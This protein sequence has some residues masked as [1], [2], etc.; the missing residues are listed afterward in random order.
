[1]AWSRSFVL[2]LI[3]ILVSIASVHAEPII[4]NHTCTD[5]SKIP[6]Y[7]IEKAK[8]ITFHY[9]HTSHGSQ[10]VSGLYAW[11]EEYPALLSVAV[12][13]SSKQGLP[14]RETPRAL[15]IY[16]GNP[17]ETYIEPEDYWDSAD[18]RS[19][20]KAV[21]GT[22]KYQ[23][24]MWSWC[25]QQSYN[26]AD[27]T[28]RYLYTLNRFEKRFP[29]MRFIYMTGH[30]DGSGKEGNL[31]KRNQQVRAYCRKHDKILFDFAD[32]E[33]YDPSGKYFLNKG[34]KDTC[35][36][37][38]GNWA[39][40]WIGAHPASLLAEISS[41]CDS[42]EHSERLNCALKGSAFW[43]M[44]ARLA[45]WDGIED[46]TP[47]QSVTDLH[48]TTYKRTSITWEWENPP[49]ADFRYATIR[50][51]G[52][53]IG[54]VK[55]P[56]HSYTMSGLAPDSPYVIRIKTV[57]KNGNVNSTFVKRKTWTRPD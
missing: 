17:P 21:A 9:A 42:C 22:G 39:E 41:N 34:A 30:L 28:R 6:D 12:R 18:G 2:L 13:E 46:A 33:S 57:D 49:D 10:I 15:R 1:M 31:H 36:Y 54:K 56:A 4:I 11:E 43:W 45:G 8:K 5:I 23:Y 27:D 35:E 29:S 16:D 44:M 38:D 52:E 7:W 14:P 32:I 37:N 48:N 55:S 26:T 3:I 50:I 20:T 24:S 47:P 53:F 19:R 40:Q 25:G 51:N